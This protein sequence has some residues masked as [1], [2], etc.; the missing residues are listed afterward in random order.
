MFHNLNN[1]PL[2][3]AHFGGAEALTAQFH[4]PDEFNANFTPPI[5][6]IR[7]NGATMSATAMTASLRALAAPA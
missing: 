2:Q 3:F 1:H 7:A 4:F 5:R 6:P